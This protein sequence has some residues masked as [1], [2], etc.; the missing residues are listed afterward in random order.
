MRK[1][2]KYMVN[3]VRDCLLGNSVHAPFPL[4]KYTRLLPDPEWHYCISTY[5]VLTET[6]IP[7]VLCLACRRVIS[8]TLEKSKCVH[9]HATPSRNSPPL[10]HSNAFNGETL[11]RREEKRRINIA[12][13]K[14]LI[15]LRDTPEQHFPQ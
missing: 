2:K 13:A 5:S 14:V 10:V 11:I 9:F 3:S 12:A 8:N 15:R 6:K 7:A 4:R 1:K